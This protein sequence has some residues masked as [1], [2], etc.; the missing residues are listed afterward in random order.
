MVERAGIFDAD[1]AGHVGRLRKT[2]QI[3]DAKACRS[4][5]L[6][7]SRNR[8]VRQQLWQDLLINLVRDHVPFRPKRSEPRAIKRRPKPYPL[9][10]K[11]RRQFKEIPHR[12]RYWKNNPRKS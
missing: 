12:T 10:N 6:T 9:L 3:V 1:F 5:G 7:P 8:K 11:P 2:V 4:A